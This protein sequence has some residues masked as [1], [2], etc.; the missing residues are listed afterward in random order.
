MFVEI[1][2]ARLLTPTPELD[3]FSLQGETN[4]GVYYVGAGEA[5][6]PEQ[7]ALGAW[8]ELLVDDP[9]TTHRSLVAH[10]LKPRDYVDREHQYLEGPGGW[11]FRLAAP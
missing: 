6:T 5:L 9:D 7:Q 1:L 10:G 11:I 2:G 4:V 8:L 3:V